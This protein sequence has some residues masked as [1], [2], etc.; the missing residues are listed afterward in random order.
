MNN[1]YSAPGANVGV[2]GAA[3]YQPRFLSAHGRI[4]RL[5]YLAY[6]FGASMLVYLAAIPLMLIA[7]VVG[8]ASAGSEGSA[9]LGVGMM[10]VMAVMYVAL[11]AVMII[12]TKRRLNDL[13]KT[14][15]LAL[16]YL[17][18]IVNL[19]LWIYIQFFPGDKTPN[20]YGPAPVANSGGVVALAVIMLVVMLLSVVGIIMAVSVP[21]YQDYLNRA[22]EMQQIQE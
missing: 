22:Q 8:G 1:P 13:G 18:P 11:I 20:Q 15:W 4:G 6:G 7:G 9:A 19:F 5:R 2:A 17:V 16:L 3:S 10:L 14:G 12:Y 21:A